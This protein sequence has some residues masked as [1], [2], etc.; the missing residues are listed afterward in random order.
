[1]M[2]DNDFNAMIGLIEMNK[3]NEEDD[4]MMNVKV[5]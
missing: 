1:M 3:I 5:E 2:E 4:E